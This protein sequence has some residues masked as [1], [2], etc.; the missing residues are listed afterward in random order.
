MTLIQ[1]SKKRLAVQ[2]PGILHGIERIKDLKKKH[3]QQMEK[4]KE[5]RKEQI[6]AEKRREKERE[7]QSRHRRWRINQAAVKIDQY[8]E[9]RA[10]IRNFPPNSY[11]HAPEHFCKDSYKILVG[12]AN[13]C[14]H[15]EKSDKDGIIPYIP[16]NFSQGF[17]DLVERAMDSRDLDFGG[18]N[19]YGNQLTAMPLQRWNIT[20]LSN[21]KMEFDEAGKYGWAHN[22]KNKTANGTIHK[23]AFIAIYGFR[24]F[25]DLESVK[26]IQARFN[27]VQYPPWEIGEKV[28]LNPLRTAWLPGVIALSAGTDYNFDLIVED[29][30]SRSDLR[31]VGDIIMPRS[32]ALK[33]K[34]CMPSKWSVW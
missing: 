12:E 9:T 20:D 23:N 14:E 13:V 28:L 8:W 7:E 22:A 26:S 32:E 2:F 29:A 16:K 15:V 17:T 34:S 19:P 31:P 1:E 21:W 3:L 4:I 10:Y 33:D 5:E 27:G 6:E 11:V 24:Q 30:P 25:G 18:T